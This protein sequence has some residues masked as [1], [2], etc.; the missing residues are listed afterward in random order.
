M[1][2][3]CLSPGGFPFPP[4]RCTSVELYLWH[5]AREL[6]KQE[7]V[8]LYG[9]ATANEGRTT[10]GNL[11]LHTFPHTDSLTYL[12]ALLTDLRQNVAD[13]TCSP[14]VFHVENRLSYTPALKRLFPDTPI[15]LN[16][17]SNVLLESLPHELVQK[18][19]RCVD[20]LVLNS[21]YLQADL[22]ARYPFLPKEKVTVINP[23][24]DL[25]QF[26]EPC[27]ERG[28]ALRSTMRAQLCVGPD[29]TVVLSVARLAPRKGI[30][31]LIDAF[32]IVQTERPNC[33]LWI[34][35][36]RPRDH[37]NSYVRSLIAKAASLPVRFFHHVPQAHLPAFYAAADLF[38]CPSQ[39]PESFGL[40]NLEAAAAGL[41]V[42]ASGRW[43]LIE[44]VGANAG[45]RLVE[46]YRTPA[47]FAAEL[48]TL[49]ASP[50]LRR[51][52]G[53]AGRRFVEQRFSWCKTAQQF[54]A[55]Y[56]HMRT[57]KGL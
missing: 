30:A 17:H 7:Q 4:A 8:L 21:N 45:G 41:P 32:Q 38:V 10:T 28:V 24:I 47:A 56:Q 15:L 9:H 19:F 23:G 33:E 54:Q 35:G 39:Q 27:S 37:K 53:T 46:A 49:L 43:G 57:R 6:A 1:V 12:R 42:I 52:A 11:T 50:E 14:S 55:L 26:P 3:C 20:A 29:R 34:V 31:E 40:V 13:H 22:L 18:S 25:A 16:L 51:Q 44:S 48:K 36:G 5:L 2:L